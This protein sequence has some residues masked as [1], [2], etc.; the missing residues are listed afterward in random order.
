MSIELHR[1]QSCRKPPEYYLLRNTNYATHQGRSVVL[2][3]T[4]INPK[5]HKIHHISLQIS[6]NLQYNLAYF[7]TFFL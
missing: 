3:D 5:I 7:Q 4:N 6:T 1:A 2:E